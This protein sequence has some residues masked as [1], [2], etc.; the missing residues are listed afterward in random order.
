L[1]QNGLDFLGVVSVKIARGEVGLGE[2]GAHHKIPHALI[3]QGSQWSLV[4]L[5][6]GF[7]HSELVIQGSC[8]CC[9]CF[10]GAFN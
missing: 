5:E 8:H 6:I 1:K 2:N 7:Y 3:S 10:L 9:C 4:A